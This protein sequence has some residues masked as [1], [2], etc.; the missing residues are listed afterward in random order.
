LRRRG[1]SKGIKPARPVALSP[2]RVGASGQWPQPATQP[3]VAAPNPANHPHHARRTSV[4]HGWA[5]LDDEGLG[6]EGA[7]VQGIK[8]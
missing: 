5:P 7:E 4:L 1:V 3:P 6:F 2:V 8:G